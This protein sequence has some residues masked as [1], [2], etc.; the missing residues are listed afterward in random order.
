MGKITIISPTDPNFSYVGFSKQ[1][2]V[3][4]SD[5]LKWTEKGKAPKSIQAIFDNSANKK[6]DEI[7][8]SEIIP[9]TPEEFT[10]ATGKNIDTNR[11]VTSSSTPSTPR[12]KV[13]NLVP[14]DIETCAQKIERI[15][16]LLV[17]VI[18]KLKESPDLA[19]YKMIAKS[20]IYKI[21][22]LADLREK[23]EPKE[24]SKL[25][26]EIYK[27]YLDGE[28]LDNLSDIYEMSIKEIKKI[29][30]QFN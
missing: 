24:E 1:C 10:N 22:D 5:Y 30:D 21:E 9:M 3:M 29:I 8:K 14:Q 11:K 12:P 6:L 27:E 23:E 7:F 19:D 2:E 17:D 25:N 15:N 20:L 16:V 26:K 13:T 4:Y 28:T 18:T